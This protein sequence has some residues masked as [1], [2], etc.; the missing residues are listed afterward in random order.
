MTDAQPLL[1]D[2]SPAKVLPRAD[3]TLLVIPGKPVQRQEKITVQAAMKLLG[4]SKATVYRYIQ[5]GHLTARQIVP[6][7]RLE[8]LRS[9]VDALARG[10]RMGGG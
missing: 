9:E 10:E 1:F 8:L 3:G 4:K 2:M 5:E 7:G 6:R